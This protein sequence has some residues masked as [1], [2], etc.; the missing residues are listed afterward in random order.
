MITGIL[1]GLLFA[2][3]LSAGNKRNEYTYTECVLVDLSL[4]LVLLFFLAVKERIYTVLMNYR[5]SVSIMGSLSSLVLAMK[6]EVSCWRL[7][8]YQVYSILIMLT[9]QVLHPR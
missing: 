1:L 8:I 7:P 5:M 9:I 6:K 4:T 2:V 3:S